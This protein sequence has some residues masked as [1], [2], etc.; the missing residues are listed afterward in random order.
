M[1]IGFGLKEPEQRF[2]FDG[3]KIIKANNINPYLVDASNVFIEKRS[4][5]LANSPSMNYGSMPIDN[6]HLIL[7]EEEKQH[8][9]SESKDNQKYI[10]QYLGGDEFINNKKRYCL[11]L[12]KAKPEDLNK[13][14]FISERLKQV[15]DFR[16]SSDRETTK[17]LA[18]Y[19]SLFGEIRQPES[20]YL[21]LP[22][23]SSE[24]REFMPIGFI[25]KSIIVNGSALVVPNATKY[26]FGILQSSM[27]NAWMRAV[28]GRMKSDYQYS[29]SLVYNNFPWCNPT[30]AQQKTIEEKA[31][32]VLDARAK[33]KKSTLA[34]LYNS[35]T[36]PPN[37]V[38]AHSDLDKAVDIAYSYEGKK[39]DADRVAFLFE[40]YQKLTAPL[41]ETEPAKKVGKTAKKSITQK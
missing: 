6:G 5:P 20:N 25:N 23:V 12:K 10:F 35:L 22:K 24:N 31:Q 16:S 30:E 15:K 11:W 33:Y 19:S 1:V 13:S 37:L 3:E 7:S 29:A 18:K 14:V 28:C 8:L 26:H 39:D 32:A 21:L 41:M 36:M 17:N 4:T 40:L 2:I 27:H 34:D 38:K 9:L